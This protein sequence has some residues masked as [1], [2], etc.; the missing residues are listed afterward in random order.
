M[1][2]AYAMG[3]EAFSKEIYAPCHDADF[4]DAYIEGRSVGDKD[5]KPN[6]RLW[7]EGN[8]AAKEK[9]LREEFPEFYES[10]DAAV[11]PMANA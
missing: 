10:F 11:I 8:E 2:T 5:N 4:L 9:Q 3:Y 1:K 7:I 6:L